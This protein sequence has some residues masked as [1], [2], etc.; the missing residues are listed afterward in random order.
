MEQLTHSFKSKS[1]PKKALN[2]FLALNKFWIRLVKFSIRCKSIN[3]ADY[4]P[5]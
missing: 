3:V 5:V 1:T 4:C 2:T